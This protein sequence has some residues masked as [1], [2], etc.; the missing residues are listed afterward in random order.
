MGVVI[1][2]WNTWDLTR[3]CLETLRA[4]EPGPARI[5]VVDNGSADGSPE[6]IAAE[7]PEVELI[8]NPENRGFAIACNQGLARVTEDYAFLL[9]TDTE[10]APD[11][12]VRL[13]DFLEGHPKHAAVA[14]KL[15]HADGST[16]RTCMAFPRRRTAWWFGTPLEKRWPESRELRRYFLR[17]WDHEDSRDVDQP[18]A[19]AFLVR[20]SVLAELGPFDESLWLYFND[21]DLSRRL[22][23]A[24]WK[25]HYLAEAKVV[26]HVGESTRRF[27]SVAGQ[28]HKNRL[29]YYRKHFGW[30]GALSAKL[31]SGLALLDL[32]LTE[33]KRRKAGEPPMDLAPYVALFKEVLRS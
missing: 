4:C 25:T 7:F 8:R 19:A 21:V 24:G 31:G 11:A 20:T 28:W 22:A 6:R 17:A 14:P 16:Q 30:S 1:P 15:V 29:T 2:S 3:T 18:P 13:A 23:S 33:R 12:L 5:V 9:N 10:V 32:W 27:G 26:H